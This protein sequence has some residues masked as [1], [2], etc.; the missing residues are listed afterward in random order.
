[1]VAENSQNENFGFG[2]IKMMK[3]LDIMMTCQ[4]QR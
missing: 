2:F 1:M 3:I 4:L